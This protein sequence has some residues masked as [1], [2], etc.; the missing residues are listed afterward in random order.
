MALVKLTKRLDALPLDALGDRLAKLRLC[1]P[2]VEE[3]M[4]RSLERRGQL[5]A[6]V[7]FSDGE[8]LQLIDGFKR[9]G[10]ARLLGWT[11]LSVQVLEV[12]E[13]TATAVVGTLH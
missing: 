11:S 3:Q 8:M 4:R 5:T 13:A 7:A 9:L 1:Q 10:A 6:V 2:A 12:D